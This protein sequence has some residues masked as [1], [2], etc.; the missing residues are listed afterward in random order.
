MKKPE[1]CLKEYC[2]KLSDENLKW[3]YHRLSQRLGGDVS[4]ATESLSSSKEIDRWLSTAESSDD[5]YDML[6]AIERAASKECE[7]R[8]LQ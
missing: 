5:F 7:K 1:V 8:S 2:Q 3:L 4:E 6:D